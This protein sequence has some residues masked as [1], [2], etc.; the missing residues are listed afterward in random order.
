M[1]GESVT[2]ALFERGLGRVLLGR[3]REGRQGREGRGGLLF[4][5]YIVDCLAVANEEE[6]HDLFVV[7]RGRGT[8]FCSRLLLAAASPEP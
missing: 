8:A 1:R 3:G 6:F 5:G 2:P 7:R 4:V